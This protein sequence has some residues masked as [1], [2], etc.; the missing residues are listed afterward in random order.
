M[1]DRDLIAR[2]ELA[3]TGN[4]AVNDGP[5]FTSLVAASDALF[6][7]DGFVFLEFHNSDSSPATATIVSSADEDGRTDDKTVTVPAAAAGAPG[8][9][10]AG[11][12]RPS[13]FNQAADVGRT[14]VN[15]ASSTLSACAFHFTP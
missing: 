11:P 15:T 4:G 7:N 13:L 6:E 2:E 3:V 1:A 12:F 8:I 14:Y 5:T 9:S 10:I